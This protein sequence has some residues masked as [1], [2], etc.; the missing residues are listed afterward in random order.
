MYDDKF[1][2]TLPEYFV[3]DSEQ[4]QYGITGFDDFAKSLL[5]IFH[6]TTLEGWSQMMYNFIDVSNFGAISV[7]FFYM[8]VV[9]G[10][11][12]LVNLIL[13]ELMQSFQKIQEENEHE[14]Q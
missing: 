8:V 2:D 12:F 6:V 1:Y 10:S 9:I 7:L 14:R 4:L 3:E 5:T 11:F 13:A